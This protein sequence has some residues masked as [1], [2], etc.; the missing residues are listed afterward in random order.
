MH[1]GKNNRAWHN[2]DKAITN[3]LELH[4]LLTSQFVAEGLSAAA[5]SKKAFGLVEMASAA[6]VRNAIEELK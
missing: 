5:A 3:R 2:V 1:T 4:R 6:D